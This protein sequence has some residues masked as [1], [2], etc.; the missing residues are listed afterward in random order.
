[1]IRVSIRLAGDMEPLSIGNAQMEGGRSTPRLGGKR[2]FRS[3][4]D[5]LV[6]RKGKMDQG[7]PEK[8]VSH[9]ERAF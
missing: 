3:V 5:D 8:G 6:I 2:I 4:S 7:R 1:M 9:E